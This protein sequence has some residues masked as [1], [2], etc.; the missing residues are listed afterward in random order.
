MTIHRKPIATN[1]HLLALKPAG[2]RLDRRG[3]GRDSAFPEGD[4]INRGIPN[5]REARLNAKV[6]RVINKEALKVPFGL[7][8][9]WMIIFVTESFEGDPR[10][11]HRWENRPQ[12]IRPHAHSLSHPSLSGGQ[13]V[14]ASRLPR[15]LMEDLQHG[16]TTQKKV[17]PRKPRP[18]PLHP[19]KPLFR[20]NGIEFVELS[21]GR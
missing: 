6:T 21:I 17:W 1:P 12:T 2:G 4:H 13:S 10:I 9:K 7:S 3:I 14:A 19:Q 15:K 18:A 11:Q 20:S 16:V 5:G 8:I